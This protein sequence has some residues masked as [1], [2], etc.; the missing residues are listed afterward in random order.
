MTEI[1]YGVLSIVSK[2]L[3]CVLFGDCSGSTISRRTT[4]GFKKALGCNDRNI[5]DQDAEHL[6]HGLMICAVVCLTSKRKEKFLL[7]LFILVG[8]IYWYHKL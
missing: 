5:T 1:N 8:L 6:V 3:N 4:K 7:G 2:K